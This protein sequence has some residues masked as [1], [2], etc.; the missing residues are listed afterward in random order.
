VWWGVAH[1]A[2]GVLYEEMM[3]IYG[4]PSGKITVP[5]NQSQFSINFLSI[6]VGRVSEYT[7]FYFFS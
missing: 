5:F 2:V 3:H 4:T 6:L 7:W 1:E